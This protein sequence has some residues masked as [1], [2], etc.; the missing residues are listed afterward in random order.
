MKTVLVVAGLG[1]VV[2]ASYA[3]VACWLLLGFNGLQGWHQF[4]EALYGASLWPVIFL[5]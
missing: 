3:F 5:W 4:T 1:Y 2:V